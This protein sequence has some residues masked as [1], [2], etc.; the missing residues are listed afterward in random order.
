[1]SDHGEE[2][3]VSRDEE[4]VEA[5][6]LETSTSSVVVVVSRSV[7]VEALTT[8]GSTIDVARHKEA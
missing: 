8:V 7:I 5:K 2:M 6:E 4:G 1:M 3:D